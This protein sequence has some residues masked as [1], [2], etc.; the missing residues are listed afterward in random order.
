MKDY[1]TLYK[2]N[3]ELKEVAILARQ[4]YTKSRGIDRTTA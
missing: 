2:S 3:L 1:N 4:V